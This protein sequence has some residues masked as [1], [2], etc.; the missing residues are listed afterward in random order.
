[1]TG[2]AY[3]ATLPGGELRHGPGGTVETFEHLV[4]LLEK[5][6]CLRA[7]NQLISLYAGNHGGDSRLGTAEIELT[8][9]NV[10]NCLM[11]RLGIMT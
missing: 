2:N 5:I 10:C 8:S 11:V 9:R 1:V 3:A 6:M 7:W 4:G